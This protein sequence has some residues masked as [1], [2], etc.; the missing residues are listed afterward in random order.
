MLWQC[1]LHLVMPIIKPIQ[2]KI[3]WRGRYEGVKGV[4]W[5]GREVGE[6]VAEARWE[7]G[8]EESK[9]AQLTGCEPIPRRSLTPVH[10]LLEASPFTSDTL[11]FRPAGGKLVPTAR[12]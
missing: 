5:M 1:K 9:R 10:L 4:G 8:C 7:G 12:R 6:M 11:Q 3:E 2:S